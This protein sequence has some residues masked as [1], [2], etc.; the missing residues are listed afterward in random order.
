M[1]RRIYV[2]KKRGF[3]VEAEELFS[4][5]K[6][7]LHLK[8]LKK[9]RI[10]NRYDIDGIDDA[11]YEAAKFTVFAEPAIDMLYEEKMPDDTRSAIFFAVEY[12][13]GQYDQRAD[14]AAQC[15]KLMSG[16]RKQAEDGRDAGDAVVKFA[17]VIVLEGRLSSKEKEAV[18]NYCVNPVDSR[19][20]AVEKPENLEMEQTEPEDVA[21]IE[22]FTDMTEPELEAYRKEMGFAMSAEDIK[23]V[24]EY[25][26]DTEKRQPTVTEIKVID[27]Y[28]SDHCRHTTFNTALY[29]IEFEE[30]PYGSIVKEAFERYLDMRKDVYG[31]RQKDLCL[32]DMACIGAKYLKKHGKADDIDES[33]EINACSIKVKAKIDGKDEDWLVMFK[34]ETHNH[35][36]EIEPFGGA[37]TCLGG[38]IRDPLSGRVYVYQAMR[39]TGAADPRKPL[40]ETLAGKLPQRKITREAASGYSSYGNQIGLAT[41]LVDELYHEDY[42]AKRMEIGAVVG[43]A[44][45][46]HVDRR[47]PEKGDVIILVGGRTGRDGC[48]GATGSSKEHTEESILECGAEVQKGNPPVERNI[49]RMF[50]RKEVATL[51]KRC[52]DFGA[53]GVSVAIGEL[54][55]GLEINLDLVPKKYEGLDGTEL[56]YRITGEDGV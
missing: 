12:L 41:G 55:D 25:Y 6:D 56:R 43:A 27:T 42:V 2:E 44:P 36:T 30:S 50:R 14:S 24:Q 3:D 21:S 19:I 40:E 37:A 52:N 51:I 49:Q 26:R 39:V 32:M 16:G 54:A 35:P 13:P 34:N 9:L 48:G 29:D 4:S 22:G 20:A 17:R 5:I 38:A 53:G 8:G 15:I 46:D 10:L 45:A 23:F 31:D 7:D 1:V 18:K 33:E 11:T 28:W 47:R